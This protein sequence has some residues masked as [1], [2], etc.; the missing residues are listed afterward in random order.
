L[1]IVEV[2]LFLNF[3]SIYVYLNHIYLNQYI[4]CIYN[5]IQL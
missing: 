4:M 5:K 1:F 3:K 2:L